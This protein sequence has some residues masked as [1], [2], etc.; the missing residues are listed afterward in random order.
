MSPKPLVTVVVPTIAPRAG[1]LS[2]ALESVRGQTLPSWLYRV[3]IQEDLTHAGAPATRH[4]GLMRVRTPWVAFLDDD[5]LLMP[6]HLEYLLQHARETDAD[7]VYSWFETL[8]A[9]CDPFPS[10]HFTEPWDKAAPRQT[11]ITTMVRTDLAQGVGFL[12]QNDVETGD[13]MVSG[14]DWLFTLRC[15]ELGKISH[16]V[17]RTWWWRHWGVGGPDRPGNTSGRGDRW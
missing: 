6:R 15:N 16:L 9:G 3:V 13:G 4:A 14:E 7:Y 10:T 5:D 2:E 11:T 8:P 17:D 12:G 1:L